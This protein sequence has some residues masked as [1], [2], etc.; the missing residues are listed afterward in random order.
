MPGRDLASLRL[1]PLTPPGGSVWTATVR[2][3][4]GEQFGV[5]A[6]ALWL[7]AGIAEI[8]GVLVAAPGTGRMAYAST[9]ERLAR[10]YHLAIARETFTRPPGVPAG[11]ELAGA[12]G[13][14][15][16]LLRALGAL[17]RQHA[18]AELAT[19]GLVLTGFGRTAVFARQLATLDPQRVVLLAVG[20]GDLPDVRVDSRVAQ[21]PAV[22]W[23]GTRDPVLGPYPRARLAAGRA[24]GALWALALAPDVVHDDVPGDACVPDAWWDAVIPHRLPARAGD[25]LLVIDSRSGLVLAEG[26]GTSWLPSPAAVASW[27]A[28]RRSAR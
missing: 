14:G 26:T 25:S 15:A 11:H 18:H 17:G 8:H 21:V 7:P 28:W 6:V 3:R 22:A 16:A 12:D 10:R 23:T 20:A 4:A 2:P 19:T 5:G 24:R 1:P 9:W 13:A 27:R